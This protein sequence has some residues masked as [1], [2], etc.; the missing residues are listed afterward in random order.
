MLVP[1]LK[2]IFGGQKEFFVV[3]CAH[4]LERGFHRPTR[5][6]AAFGVCETC[7]REI[8]AS[9]AL[10]LHLLDQHA[11][12]LAVR[13]LQS[14]LLDGVGVQNAHGRGD[15]AEFKPIDPARSDVMSKSLFASRYSTWP[16]RCRSWPS[17]RVEPAAH[18]ATNEKRRSLGAA[19]KQSPSRLRVADQPAA[20]TGRFRNSGT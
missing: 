10:L 18:S 19:L 11:V 7:S 8:R 1:F 16:A 20:R 17:T 13:L 12:L 3:F 14:A 15:F 4:G 2:G 9:L 6:G 5:P